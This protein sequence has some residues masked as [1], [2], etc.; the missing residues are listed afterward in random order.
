TDIDHP[1]LSATSGVRF[2]GPRCAPR[3]SDPILRAECHAMLGFFKRKP[4]VVGPPQFWVTQ[5]DPISMESLCEGTL[6]HGSIGSGKTTGPG[7]ALARWLLRQG[8]G[9]CVHTA[10]PGECSRWVKMC[11]E[12]ERS[13]DLVRAA[14]DTGFKCDLLNEALS[15]PEAS[16][17]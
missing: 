17:A 13:A 2:S 10:K 1:F 9:F 7:E 15:H 5:R 3:Y 12:E 4:T 6:I 16:A 11:A 14:P 8:A